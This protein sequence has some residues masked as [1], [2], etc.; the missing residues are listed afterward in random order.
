MSGRL[1]FMLLIIPIMF[2]LGCEKCRDSDCPSFSSLIHTVNLVDSNM[3]S[4]YGSSPIHFDRTE[5]EI[6][7]GSAGV[8]F[9][10]TLVLIRQR[11]FDS[12]VIVSFNYSISTRISVNTITEDPADECCS[13]YE[14]PSDVLVDG[15]SL[16]DTCLTII[17]RVN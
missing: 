9:D 3:R 4:V 17:V 5:I 11:L 14:I 6:T 8:T 2:L 13:K 12:N 15:V 7:S 10:D 1:I 16:C